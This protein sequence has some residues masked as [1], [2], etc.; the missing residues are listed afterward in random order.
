MPLALSAF[1]IWISSPRP[2]PTAVH[3][4][5]HDGLSVFDIAA[6]AWS[7]GLGTSG[8]IKWDTFTTSCALHQVVQRRSMA[9]AVPMLTS[10]PTR[11]PGLKST[12]AAH[13]SLC[14]S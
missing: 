9:P 7:V 2:W 5:M 13:S 10:T 3:A 6:G 14:E 8:G 11:E 12:V 1:G 4:A